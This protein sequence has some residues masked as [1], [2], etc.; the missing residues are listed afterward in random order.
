MKF[1]LGRHKPVDT[2]DTF[3]RNYDLRMVTLRRN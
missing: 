2:P 1:V 3:G